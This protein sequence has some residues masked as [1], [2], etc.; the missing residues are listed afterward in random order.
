MRFLVILL[1]LLTPAATVIA[2]DELPNIQKLVAQVNDG[3]DED[4]REQLPSLVSNYP[5][6]PGVL[7]L[8]ALLTREGADA[9]RTYQSI[10]DNFPKS[11]WADDALYKVYQFY[12]ALGLYRTAELKLN[13]LKTSYPS[14]AYAAAAANDVPV[15]NLPAPV[16]TDQAPAETTEKPGVPTNPETVQELPTEKAPEDVAP[17]T[18]EPAPVSSETAIPVRFSLQVGA[19]TLQANAETQKTRFETLGYSAGMVSKVRDTRALFIVLVGDNPTYE[20]AKKAAAGVKKKT[21]IE[22]MVISR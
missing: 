21:G 10:V 11:E 22:A 5:N 12:Y 8:Q 9:V 14:S 19:F 1:I 18:T 15:S 6:N 20:E 13:Q 16:I 4:V 7:Y 3:A 2:Q 17:A